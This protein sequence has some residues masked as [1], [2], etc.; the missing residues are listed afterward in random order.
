LKT[1]RNLRAGFFIVRGLGFPLNPGVFSKFPRRTRPPFLRNAILT[2]AIL[3]EL[4]AVGFRLPNQDPEAI[5]RGNAFTATA[6]NPSA[7]YYNPAGITQLEGNHLSTGVYSISTGIDFKSPQ[8]GRAES[9]S[10]FQFVPQIYYVHSPS[11]SRFSYGLG[12]YAP[13]GL[14][15][16]YGRD[17]PFSTLAI[18]GTLV[19]ATL[20]PVI[21][22]EVNSELSVGFGMAL[23]YS[24]I[25]ISRAIGLSPGDLFEFEGDD[26]SLN[27]NA[28]LLWHPSSEWSFGL[29][30]RS[31]T[32]MDYKGK[33]TATGSVGLPVSPIRASSKGTLDFPM[34]IAAG[35]SYRPNENWNIEVGLDWTDWDSVNVTTLEGTPF[36]DVPFPFN[37][38]SGFMYQIGVTH[39][40]ESGHF[41]SAGYIYSDN[42]VP[43]LSFSPLNP[44]SNLHLWSIGFGKRGDR[45]SWAIGYHAAYN[46]GRKVTGNAS[47]SLTGE[48]ADGEYETLNHAVNFS[49]RISF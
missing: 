45:H 32:E 29:N 1:R 37:Y 18:D 6:D 43:D 9:D 26:F 16:D 8:D 40:F 49:Y 25:S 5:A 22:Y 41:I 34:N 38:E 17:T 39:K 7:I 48:T 42:S 10:S 4:S 14:G 15:I 24:D 27:F 23:N 3:G 46:G 21:A 44:D 31:A 12:I 47:S 2:F 20:N 19:F 33:S 28:G 36:G 30:F 13:F 35:I 11:D